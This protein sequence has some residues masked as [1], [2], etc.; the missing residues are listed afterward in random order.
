[1]K[2]SI[3]IDNNESLNDNWW[4]WKPQWQLIT[5]K[6]SMTIDNNESLNDNW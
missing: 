1:M 5:M 2:A 3:T 4:Q 6:A